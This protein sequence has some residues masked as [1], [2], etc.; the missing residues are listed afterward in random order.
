MELVS[1]WILRV[2]ILVVF[3][4]GIKGRRCNYFRCDWLRETRSNCA[5]RC[6]GG[7]P[8]RRIAR[9][10]A[11]S[12]LIAAVAELLI[13]RERIDIAPEHM[14]QTIVC[15]PQR[16]E[17]HLHRF[18]MSGS[19]S[20]NLIVGWVYDRARGVTARGGKHAIELVV[21]RLHTPET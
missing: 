14:Q 11:A 5:K 12:I 15:D 16:V 17:Y 1:Q 20:R 19:A 4:G 18:R 10:N 9:I 3:L 2:V 7:F 21:R 6:L 8:L 13:A